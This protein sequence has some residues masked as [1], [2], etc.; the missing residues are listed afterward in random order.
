[1]NDQRN[2]QRLSLENARIV[3]ACVMDQSS[4]L[5]TFSN[6]S[7]ALV[8]SEEVKELAMDSGAKIIHREEVS[9]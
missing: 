9:D 3:Q 8:N 5:L 7:S 4:I 2:S 6:G 1:M